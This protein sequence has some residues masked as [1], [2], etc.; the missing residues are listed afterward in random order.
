MCTKKPIQKNPPWK[1]S[2]QLLPPHP[3]N[4]AALVS[5]NFILQGYFSREIL[6][7]K[8]GSEDRENFGWVKNSKIDFS[9]ARNTIVLW[10][11]QSRHWAKCLRS[12][13]QALVHL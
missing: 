1:A 5:S 12:C 11:I 3:T 2:P 10:T 9:L 7:C 8:G 6:F 4:Y 13:W